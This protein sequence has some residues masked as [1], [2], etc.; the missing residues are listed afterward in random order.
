MILDRWSEDDWRTLSLLVRDCKKVVQI[1]TFL[2][3]SAECILVDSHCHL[4][5]IDHYGGMPHDIW[6]DTHKSANTFTA[7]E[8]IMVTL[9]RL[10]RFY[11]AG[12]MTLIAGESLQVAST[13]A[14]ESIDLVFLDGA[15]DYESIKADILAWAPKVQKD[16]KI[17]GHDLD[18]IA[19]VVKQEEID[20]KANKDK[21][22]DTHL[23]YGV[24]KAVTE[25]FTHIKLAETPSTVW[26]AEKAWLK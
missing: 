25:L 5:T 13:F 2:G 22:P 9:G 10:D 14:D 18:R 7:G 1:G 19:F 20:K 16:G 11:S 6:Q 21:C 17:S 8:A 15:H 3:A 12:R 26:W 4:T 24:A 23:H